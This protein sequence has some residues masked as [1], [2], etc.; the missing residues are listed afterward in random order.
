MKTT[1]TKLFACL[2]AIV[3]LL[4]GCNNTVVEETDVETTAQ[5]EPAETDPIETEAATE[6]ETEPEVPVIEEDVNAESI[7]IKK[8][9]G[10][11]EQIYIQLAKTEAMKADP[12]KMDFKVSYRAMD[13]ARFVELDRELY[14]DEGDYIGCYILGLPEGNY[15]VKIEQGEG[16][17]Y[18]RTTL[19]DIHVERQDRSGYA[20]FK[21]EE[22][23]G[24]YN[25]DGSVKEDAVILYLN[26]AN[27]NTLTLEI[28]GKIYTGLVEI[29]QAKQYMEEPLI[30]RVT[31]KVTTNQWV[32]KDVEPRYTDNSNFDEEE[33]WNNSFSTE[34]GENL[35]GLPVNLNDAKAGKYY[36]YTTTPEGLSE[37][38]TGGYPKATK[39]IESG[40][41]RV[42]EKHVGKEVYEDDDVLNYLD[43]VLVSNLTIEGVGTTAEFYQFGIRFNYPN[44]IEV[45]N[46]TFSKYPHDA[47]GFYGA[48]DNRDTELYGNCWIHN[49][50]FNTGYTA[51]HL[52]TSRSQLNG[53][54]SVDMS[55][56]HNM[57]ISYNKFNEC[58]KTMLVGA[59]DWAIC[60]D[61][62]LHH[63]YFNTCSY[64]LPRVRNSNVHSYNNF[65][66]NCYEHVATGGTTNYFSEYNWYTGGSGQWYLNLEGITV[67]AYKD[68]YEWVKEDITDWG[69]MIA[70]DREQALEN[71]QCSPDG[72]TDYSKFD[73]D[74]ELFYYDVENKCSDVENLLDTSNRDGFSAI[75]YAE[76]QIRRYAGAANFN[77]LD[78]P[79]KTEE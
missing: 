64:R 79:D 62:T 24:G 41:K 18:A 25:K 59:E 61:I 57:T 26:N 70:A 19:L 40:N 74:P 30:I 9:Q 31:D 15:C 68:T 21:R 35:A 28:D 56:V 49:N 75:Q 29:L 37:V 16:E 53:D 47:L 51:W 60:R 52:K 3:L 4:S 34:A 78:L 42:D 54:G 27:K 12:E 2:L 14:L 76:R 67:K 66:I 50:T 13:R 43:T 7:S 65:Y 63:N 17:N 46:M 10:L 39:I 44:S 6:A 33:F 77:C 58:D 69:V 22:G 32:H 11:N 45:R 36:S 1:A 23:I 5:T 73:T 48:D 20:Y 72:A 38:R 55:S 71:N 8:K